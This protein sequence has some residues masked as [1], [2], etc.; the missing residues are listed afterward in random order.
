MLFFWYFVALL[1][2]GT[3]FIPIHIISMTMWEIHIEG[4]E[5][6]YK[7]LSKKRT[8]TFHEIKR[9]SSRKNETRVYS[10]ENKKLFSIM[11]SD[12]G[13]DLFIECLT[14]RNIDIA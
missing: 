2:V 8:F 4:E 3:V 14:A 6:H 10:A 13:Y 11:L 12:V 5:I 9:A 1:V 7:S